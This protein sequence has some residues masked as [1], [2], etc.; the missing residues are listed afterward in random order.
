[1]D[2]YPW[3]YRAQRGNDTKMLP[4]GHGN[5]DIVSN[6]PA[7]TTYKDIRE[8]KIS[9]HNTLSNN[10]SFIKPKMEQSIFHGTYWLNLNNRVTHKMD[11]PTREG[12]TFSFNNE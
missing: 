1:M 2:M 10:N 5:V 6:Q 11:S 8:I 12:G 4:P 3:W 7:A 9:A